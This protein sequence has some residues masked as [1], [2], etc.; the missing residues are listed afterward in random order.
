MATEMREPTFWILTVLA[1]G[2][3]HGYSLLRET[4][5]ISDGRVQLKVPTLYAALERMTQEGSVAVD[6]EEVVDGRPRRYFRLTPEGTERLRR[7]VDR[8]EANAA[9]ARERL[10]AR[11]A[12]SIAFGL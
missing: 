11:P 7:E 8:L 9:K 12:L 2:R 3:R 6:G 5:E 10:T 1:A 4:A